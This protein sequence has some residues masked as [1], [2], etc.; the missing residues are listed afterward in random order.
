MFLYLLAS[1]KE[2]RTDNWGQLHSTILPA[3]MQVNKVGF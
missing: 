1:A 2:E 3:L